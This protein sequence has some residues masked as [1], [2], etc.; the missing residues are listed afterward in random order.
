MLF[1][2]FQG[3]QIQAR[4][5]II[6]G[7]QHYLS[8][9]QSNMVQY[10]H[11]IFNIIFISSEYHRTGQLASQVLTDTVRFMLYVINLL[12]PGVHLILQNHISSRLRT[13]ALWA[14]SLANLVH[15]VPGIVRYNKIHY[16]ISMPFFQDGSFNWF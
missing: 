11:Q 4:P 13:S 3:K 15:G 16:R 6:A 14:M 10:Q 9:K 8:K 5:Y 2:I 1:T 12:T 7:M